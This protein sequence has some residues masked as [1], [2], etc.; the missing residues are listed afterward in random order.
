MSLPYQFASIIPRL[1]RIPI[2]RSHR[3]LLV[4]LAFVWIFEQADLNTFAISAPALMHYLHFTV[5]DISSVTS[6]FFFGSLFGAWI[7][8]YMADSVGRKKALAF[9]LL[10][11]SFSSLITIFVNSVSMFM[12]LRFLTGVGCQAM[13]L[14]GMTYIGE[15]F[16]KERRGRYQ[17]MI[18]TIS[19]IGIPGMAFFAKAVIPTG[20]NGWRFVYLLG[21]VGLILLWFIYKYFVESPRWLE[22]SGQHENAEKI[23]S[24]FE[25]EATSSGK[26]LMDVSNSQ[27]PVAER[28]NRIADIF[29]SQ[30]RRR[31]IV[32]ALLWITFLLAFYGFQAWVP[33]LLYKRGFSLVKSTTFSAWI[34]IGAIPGALLAWPFIDKYQRRWAMVILTFLL[35]IA[36]YAYGMVSSDTGII[37]LGMTNQILMFTATSYAFAYTPEVFPTRIRGTANGFGNGLGR[38]G[39]AAGAFIVGGIYTTFGYSAVFAFVSVCWLIAGSLLLFFGINTKNRSLEEISH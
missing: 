20:V 28:K 31:T 37:I 39:V 1:E 12:V 3:R 36:A 29:S 30:Y 8:G 13:S 15:L 7:G 34:T 24:N 10:L 38:L 2:G 33:T 6:V 26:R 14:I 27:V 25:A 9:S 32:I 5:K 16:P 22:G 18:L 21:A 11:Y 23:V 19:V 17:S 35:A 4:I